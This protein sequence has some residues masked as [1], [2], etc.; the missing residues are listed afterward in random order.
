M[1]QN[2]KRLM[3]VIKMKWLPT[4]DFF[5]AR[6]KI[7]NRNIDYW[8]R[9]HD[10]Y[11]GISENFQKINNVADVFIVTGKDKRSVKTFLNSF[12]INFLEKKI[13]DKEAADNK[14]GAL[15]EIAKITQKRLTDIIFLDDNIYHLLPP[16]QNGCQVFMA[17]WGYHCD[18]HLRKAKEQGIEV[19]Q[20]QNWKE[21][22]TEALGRS[23]AYE[24]SKSR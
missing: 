20:L 24:S 22:I 1:N 13:Y 6:D 12:G 8:V 14:L 18:G 9:L 19:L 17:G 15:K 21:R 7:R 10:V 11:E 23:G 5:L 3:S 16:K 2:L 4:K